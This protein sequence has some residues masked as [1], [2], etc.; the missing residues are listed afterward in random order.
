MDHAPKYRGLGTGN[1]SIV[2]NVFAVSATGLIR[3]KA[4]KLAPAFLDT[5]V[6]NMFFPG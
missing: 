6:F 4:P 5:Y 1:K 3:L 2:K